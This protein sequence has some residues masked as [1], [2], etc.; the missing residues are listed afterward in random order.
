MADIGDLYRISLTVT[1]AAGDLTDPD[2]VEITVTSPSGA[3][4]TP[5]P[6]SDGVGLYHADVTLT[7]AGRWRWV[8]ATTE[9]AEVDHGH[10]DVQVDPPS[11]L[12][13]LATAADIEARLA[14]ALTT[15]EN[16]RVAALLID[17]SAAIRGATRPRQDFD[18]VVDDTV[19]LRPIGT[20][21]TLPQRPVTAVTSVVAI[22]GQDGI[23]DITLSSYRWNGA[24][25]IEIGTGLGWRTAIDHDLEPYHLDLWSPSTY[26][27]TYS[28]GDPI[29]PDD[30]RGKCCQLVMRCLTP[31][32]TVTPEGMTQMTVGQYTEQWQQAAGAPGPVP[33]MTR[34][35]LQDLVNWGY[36]RTANSIGIRL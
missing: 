33:V 31:T 18:H 26:R 22:S 5:T 24:N 29:T 25:E 1:D 36:R 28:H 2:D 9:P 13:P 17:A 19:V 32:A 27:V 15:E 23:P 30:I 20:I 21:L 6:T 16:T 34:A 10:V 7:A 11:R 3:I 35:D 14:R 8:W 12:Q 4:S